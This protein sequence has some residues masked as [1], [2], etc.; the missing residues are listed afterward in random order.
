MEE[1]RA[2]VLEN[3]DERRVLQL[4]LGSDHEK[5]LADLGRAADDAHSV[6]LADLALDRGRPREHAR[7]VASEDLEQRA[8]LELADDAR[9]D[10]VSREPEVERAS[11]GH[12]L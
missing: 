10:A 5:A 2:R 9:A 6:L 8:V 12:R 1:V 3:R 11:Q 4:P 7:S